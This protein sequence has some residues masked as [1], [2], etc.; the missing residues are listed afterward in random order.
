MGPFLYNNNYLLK[1]IT[2][3][4]GNV[5]NPGEYKHVREKLY[6]PKGATLGLKIMYRYYKILAVVIPL[7]IAIALFIYG[8]TD[9]DYGIVIVSIWI[10]VSA[11]IN[12]I[13]AQIFNAL[14]TMTKAA[15]YY[16]AVIQKAYD[17]HD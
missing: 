1:S 4:N 15:E 8:L 14:I 16:I 11:I 13:V 2:I 10:A 17:V 12:W 9:S 5:T 7:F 3:M 6:V